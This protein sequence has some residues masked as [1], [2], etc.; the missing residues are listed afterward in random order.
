M[1]LDTKWI[2]YGEILQIF[3]HIFQPQQ[4]PKFPREKNKHQFNCE[5]IVLYVHNYVLG[6][7]LMH[8]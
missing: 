7:H 6:L 4:T 5:K 1:L 8:F 2:F 3:L